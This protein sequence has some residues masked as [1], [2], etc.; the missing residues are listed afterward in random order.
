MKK[1][2]YAPLMDNYRDSYNH[3]LLEDEVYIEP[4]RYLSYYKKDHIDHTYWKCHAWKHYYKN[5]FVIFSQQDIVVEYDKETGILSENSFNS[6]RFDE[7]KK[8]NGMPNIP[9]IGGDQPTPYHGVAIGQ[10]TEHIFLWSSSKSKNMWVETLPP[11]N[12]IKK[13]MEMISAEYPFSRWY[14]PVTF[15][16]RFNEQVTKIS[17][18]EPIGLLK[19]RNFDKDE[20]FFLEKFYPS[21]RLISKSFNHATLKQ[22]LPGKSWEMIKDNQ[23]SKCP[24]KNI[25]DMGMNQ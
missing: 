10:L 12:L 11:N 3:P 23:N 20:D 7:G 16:Y 4:Q 5:T 24:F 14:R 21:D 8:A 25:F 17:R 18:G 13:G 19:F 9:I 2:Q 15:A 22:Y 1:I 6:F